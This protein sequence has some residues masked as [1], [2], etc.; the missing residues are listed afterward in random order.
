MPHWP[1]VLDLLVVLLL[2]VCVDTFPKDE[3]YI[4]WFEK[5]GFKDVQLKG[6]GQKWYCRVRRHGLMM[7]CSVTR[8]KSA[9]G[10]SPLQ[11]IYISSL[12]YRLHLYIC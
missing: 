8:V 5:A 3:E 4:D 7:G 12:S 1:Y 11:V 2:C 6:I 9:S 10:D